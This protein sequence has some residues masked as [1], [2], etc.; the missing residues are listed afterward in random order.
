LDERAARGRHRLEI[1]FRIGA[2]FVGAALAAEV[3][4]LSGVL[5]RR[6]RSLR[7]NRHPANWISFHWTNHYA[8]IIKRSA[9]W[10]SAIRDVGRGSA[11]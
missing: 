8:A 9:N 6:H 2:E 5:G 1:F 7:V 3:V 4:F 11:S 10:E